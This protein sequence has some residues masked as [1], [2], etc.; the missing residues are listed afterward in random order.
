MIMGDRLPGGLQ[1]IT[2]SVGA[3]MVAS[4]GPLRRPAAA[5]DHADARSGSR[6]VNAGAIRHIFNQA[7]R[8]A[9]DR[10]PRPAED[11]FLDTARS[12][13]PFNHATSP[14]P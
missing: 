6:P 4:P 13:R 14:Q 7:A 2:A 1:Q 8:T 11:T 12:L 9:F 5:P 3:E 10:S